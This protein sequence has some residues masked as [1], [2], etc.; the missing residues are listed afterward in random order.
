M[1]TLISII[2]KSWKH[3]VETGMAEAVPEKIAEAM[4]AE[5]FAKFRM[6]QPKMNAKLEKAIRKRCEVVRFKKKA[7]ILEYG[8]VCRHCFFSMKGLVTAVLEAE[9]GEEYVWFMGEQDIIISVESF[10]EQQF[11]LERLVA[12]EETDC[13]ALHWDDLQWI[14]DKH[15]AFERVGRLLTE[16][17]Y[18]QA[19]K[20]TNWIRLEAKKRYLALFQ[21]Y[22]KFFGRVPDGAL[23]SYLGIA[24]ATLSRIRTEAHKEICLLFPKEA[25]ASRPLLT[26]T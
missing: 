11:S 3:L 15:P 1:L 5:M 23:A 16:Y 24:Q 18:R 6:L 20:R 2:M 14:Y 8:E 12:L 13:I 17:Y 21:D 26:G 7:V 25:N 4:F 19:I 10:Y 9:K 22:P